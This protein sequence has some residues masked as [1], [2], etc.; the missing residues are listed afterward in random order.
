MITIGS[1]SKK[2]LIDVKKKFYIAVD[3]DTK[4]N[5]LSEKDCNVWDRWRCVRVNFK[6]KGCE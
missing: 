3:N 4:G 2:Y 6:G 1:T 5:E